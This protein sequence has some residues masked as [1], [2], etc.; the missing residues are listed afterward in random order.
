MQALQNKD[1]TVAGDG[2]QTRS[3]QYVDDLINGMKS[4]METTADSFIGPVNIGNPGEFTILE[5][6]NKVI[7]MTN[8]KSKIVYIPL[9]SDDPMQRK[10]DITLAKQTLAWTPKIELEEGLKKTIGYF[11]ALLAQGKGK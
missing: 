5:L 11:D 7:E 9:P 2:S 10:P 8:S 3:F 6:A 4:M 1:I